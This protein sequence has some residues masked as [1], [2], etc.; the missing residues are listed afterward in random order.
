MANF[1]LGKPVVTAEPSVV[2][3]AGLPVGQHRFRLEVLTD[4][5]QRSPPDEALVQVQAS[6]VPLGIVPPVLT[7]IVP[8]RPSQP[9]SP[10]I[11][12]TPSPL[13]SPPSIAAPVATP[14]LAP[15]AST[16]PKKTVSP[17]TT[18]PTTNPRHPRKKKE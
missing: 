10:T 2:V 6:T 18:S 12:F 8:S 9:L 7:P 16:L 3:D 1:E 13:P 4:T 14:G 15:V 5:G 17:A 11:P